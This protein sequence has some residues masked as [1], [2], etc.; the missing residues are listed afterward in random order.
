[1]RHRHVQVQAQRLQFESFCQGQQHVVAQ[2]ADHDGQN[3]L[4]LVIALPEMQPSV[5]LGQ[6]KLC[7]RAVALHGHQVGIGAGQPVPLPVL[8]GFELQQRKPG[9]IE[10]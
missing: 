7:G 6:E 5:K 2:H 4:H 1:M 3:A 8:Q 10:T 9:F